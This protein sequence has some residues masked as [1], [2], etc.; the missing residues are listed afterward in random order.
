VHEIS[1]KITA[2]T[3]LAFSMSREKDCGTEMRQIY[4]VLYRVSVSYCKKI[5]SRNI[6]QKSYKYFHSVYP[7]KLVE[8]TDTVFP[9]RAHFF[10]FDQVNFIREFVFTALENLSNP[11]FTTPLTA[12]LCVCQ[13]RL[14]R[15]EEFLREIC[16]RRLGTA[17]YNT[18]RAHS[19]LLGKKR[20]IRSTIVFN[21]NCFR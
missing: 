7:G 19:F 5:Q 14:L 6:H 15:V 16:P 9:S 12:L 21:N 8:I 11:C 13:K 2:A 3:A 10:L 18:G 17:Q 1:S 4:I 20:K